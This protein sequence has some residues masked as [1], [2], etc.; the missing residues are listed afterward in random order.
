MSSVDWV[1]RC[2]CRTAWAVTPRCLCSYAY[3]RV[4][5]VGPQTG[6]RSQ[7]LL[8]DMWRA[9][10]PLLAHRSQR[11][12]KG[13]TAAGKARLEGLCPPVPGR[14]LAPSKRHRHRHKQRHRHRLTRVGYTMVTFWSWIG[15]ARTSTFTARTPG[16]TE[17]G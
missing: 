5:A 8:Y 2:T 17:N 16:Y 10:A 4:V 15:V 1:V 3:G 6:E 9:I 11:K 14:A 12:D 7:E 13:T